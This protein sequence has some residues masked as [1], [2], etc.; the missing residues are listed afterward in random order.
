[1]IPVRIVYLHGFASSPQSGKAQYFR[2]RFAE[3][4]IALEIPQ[5]DRGDFSSLTI[6][7][8]LEVVQQAVANRPAV[9]MGSS[10]GGYIA[11]LYAAR[12][13]EIERLVL[14]APAFQFASRWRERY[15]QQELALWQATGSYPIFHYGQQR[16]VP[17][18]YRFVEDAQQYEDE[19]EFG[20]PALVF[21][22]KRDPV[23]PVTVSEIYAARRPNITL[24]VL[25]SGH[26]LTDV[27]E[28][29][30]AQTAGFL[31][32]FQRS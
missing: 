2:R 19:P 15:S 18:S 28:E 22:G 30:W 24:R 20:Q 13:P 32:Q 1:M 5:L 10:L 7:G 4:G 12:H 26:E 3:R 6:T 31:D 9:L 27:V 29:M 16:E 21:H 17:L 11:G 23:V 25:D 14:M 8:Q